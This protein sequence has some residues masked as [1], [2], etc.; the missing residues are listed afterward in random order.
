M[1]ETPCLHEPYPGLG[2]CRHCGVFAA[3][4]PAD[5]YA[6][7]YAQWAVSTERFL[8][9]G[10][11][12]RKRVG[13]ARIKLGRFL[14]QAEKCGVPETCADSHYLLRGA[15]RLLATTEQRWA[16]T[17]GAERAQGVGW[18]LDLLKQSLDGLGARS[19]SLQ[20]RAARE[21]K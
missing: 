20:R 7:I 12:T 21:G 1:I 9:I 11:P 6:R 14:A 3:P 4:T 17:S 8:R 10:R 18:V 2:V 5:P 13:E 16:V 15:H 19:S